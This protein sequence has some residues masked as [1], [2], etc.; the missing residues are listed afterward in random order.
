MAICHRN[1]TP[2]VLSAFS[3]RPTLVKKLSDKQQVM[4]ARVLLS[5][6]FKCLKLFHINTYDMIKNDL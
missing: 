3:A 5:N 1:V 4:E 2:P 6:M